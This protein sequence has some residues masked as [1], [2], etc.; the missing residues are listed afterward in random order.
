MA[1]NADV[2]QHI[3]PAEPVVELEPV[4][5][6]WTVGETEDVL[7]EQVAVPIDDAAASD[8]FVEQRRPP[9]R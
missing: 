7:G 4:K 1:R 3:A 6:A 8:A 9:S 5:D 2:V